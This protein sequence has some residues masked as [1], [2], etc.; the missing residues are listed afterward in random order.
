MARI[1]TAGRA[2]AAR[3]QQRKKKSQIQERRKKEFTYR[4]YTLEQ[5]QKM[6]MEQLTNLFPSRV[7]RKIKRG[8][9]AEELAFL[10]RMEKSDGSKAVRTHRREMLVLPSFVGKKVAIYNGKEFQEITVVPEM[11]AHSLGEFAATRRKVK[12]SGPGVGATKSSK[13]MP[14]K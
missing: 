1:K 4:G 6:S 9:H 3:R 2:K 10:E 14:L 8:F 5:L 11:I 13:Y 12:H 7:R